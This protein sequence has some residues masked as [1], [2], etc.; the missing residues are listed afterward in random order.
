MNMHACASKGVPP[1]A[2]SSQVV[3]KEPQSEGVRGRKQRKVLV[4]GDSLVHGDKVKNISKGL[5][6]HFDV[7]LPSSVL[8]F[9]D[10]V[11]WVR[12]H[13]DAELDCI[14]MGRLF[15]PHLRDFDV[16]GAW[17][18]TR[19]ELLGELL[20]LT[21]S[22]KTPVVFVV[23]RG[24]KEFL[25]RILNEERVVTILECDAFNPSTLSSIVN[26]VINKR[27][28]FVSP[29]NSLEVDE[30]K[31]KEFM[32]VWSNTYDLHM[33]RTRH[34]AVMHSLL[35]HF[36]SYVRDVIVD[37]GCGTCTPLSFILGDVIA[38]SLEANPEKKVKIVC[39]D[40][41][42]EMLTKGKVRVL[43]TLS[44]YNLKGRVD[45]S[46]L[47]SNIFDFDLSLPS[48]STALA[49][50]IIHWLKDK[51]GF[52]RKLAQLLSPGAYFIS[53]EEWPL[54][55]TP[56]SHMKEDFRDAI[57]SQTTP[58]DILN[59]FYPLLRSYSFEL[60]ESK[61]EPI[62][63]NHQMYGAVFVKR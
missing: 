14:V 30:G 51:E 36:A 10:L 32:D 9:E 5:N 24:E 33:G 39:V 29:K 59:Q 46:F 37:L 48:N 13:V 17:E 21:E 18:E 57:N 25:R 49:T 16:E 52:V 41:S 45:L 61:V 44:K 4:I 56:S 43:D 47:C 7:S 6:R 62:D 40:M 19:L 11:D 42:R 38:P 20:R 1:L 60:L 22:Y 28:L 55:V 27:A 12:E 2:T 35:T 63:D 3:R 8:T 26:D 53:V 31:I 34:Y 50:Y 58:I 23:V 54:V 15:A